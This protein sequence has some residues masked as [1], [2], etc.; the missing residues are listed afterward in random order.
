MIDFSSV[1]NKSHVKIAHLSDLHIGLNVR[2]DEAA[3]RVSKLLGHLHVDHILVTG[4]I[5]HR[6]RR[7]EF[8]RFQDIFL[9]HISAGRLI[10]VPGNHDRLGD[11]LEKVFMF[12]ERVQVFETPHLYVV[13]LNSTGDH[14][15][16]WLFGQGLLTVED[17]ETV[18]DAFISAPAD[19]LS[20]L[21]MHHHPL[22][23]PEDGMPERLTTWVGLSTSLELELGEEMLNQLKGKCDIVLH[24]HRHLPSEHL[25]RHPHGRSLMV[26]NAGSTTLL[27]G[28]RVL[29]ANG[30]A[31]TS[32]QW[33]SLPQAHAGRKNVGEN[34]VLQ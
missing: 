23:L 4:D 3:D 29:E 27:Q 34:L 17:V 5:T 19:K 25:F 33:V 13:K 16:N 11:D 9:S 10:A 30:S 22:P 1:R 24:G 2:V 26:Y 21:M 15:R 28:F 6:G 31:L 7:A 8:H 14:N 12:G 18:H 20:V 32:A